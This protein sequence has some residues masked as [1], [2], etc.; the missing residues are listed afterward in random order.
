MKRLTIRPEAC[1]EALAL[2]II[3]AWAD[4]RLEE[5]EQ[6]G[7]RAAAG[8]LNLAKELRE[9]LDELLKKP[10]QVEELLVDEL[11]P[12]EKAFAYVAASWLSGV[13]ANVD[14]KEKDVLARAAAHL[15]ISAERQR[16]LD[17]IARDLEPLREGKPSWAT[18]VIALFKA[19]PARFETEGDAY[20]VAFE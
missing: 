8:V 14:V 3:M 13:D 4:G 9:R 20:E 18:E 11:T 15:G 19:I 5:S 7:V 2:L 1:V 16:E 17:T 12:R 10:I 6:A